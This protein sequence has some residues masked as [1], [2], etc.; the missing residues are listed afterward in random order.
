MKYVIGIII[1][2]VLN[3]QNAFGSMEILMPEA[4]FNTRALLRNKE[5]FSNIN[6][7][8]D[9]SHYNVFSYSQ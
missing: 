8:I 2:I 6:L 9:S 7:H 1:E 3:L 5:Y 4:N